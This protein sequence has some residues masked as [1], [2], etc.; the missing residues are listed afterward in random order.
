MELNKYI[1]HTL[2]K[3]DATRE[4][5]EKLLK[6]ACE[7]SFLGVCV[8]PCNVKLAKQFL[9]ETGY[10]EVKVVT[11]VGFPLGQTTTENKV[12]ETVDAIKNG[13]DE[14]DMVI[15]AG[16]LK[17]KDYNYIVDEISKIKA[18]CQG[19]NLKVI[20]ET[21][22][23]TKDEIKKACELCIQGGADFVKTSTGFVKNGV[24]AKEEDVK[25]MYETVKDAG[26]KVKASG[27]IRDKEAAIKMIEAGASR[28]GTSSGAKICS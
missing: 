26:L 12:L 28:L 3:Q 25:L 6:E 20:L 21:D 13:A 1:E 2:L 24:G 17:D 22:L 16:R 10:N 18:F 14:I 8:N 4:D 5:L 7:Y 19:R 11:V 9:K 23:L 15:N 27:G